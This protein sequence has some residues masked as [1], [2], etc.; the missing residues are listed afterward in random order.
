MSYAALILGT[1]GMWLGYSQ[2]G[3]TDLP[4]AATFSAAMLL[5]L[6][7]VARRRGTQPI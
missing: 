7:W 2:V 4:L 1:S 3:V 6:P 5:C